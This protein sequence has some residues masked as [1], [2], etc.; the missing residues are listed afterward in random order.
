MADTLSEL[1]KMDSVWQQT[2]NWQPDDQQQLQFQRLYQLVLEGNCQLNLTRITDPLEFWEKHLWDSL[3]GVAPL[4]RD[5][6][7]RQKAEVGSVGGGEIG[8]DGA[9]PPFPNLPHPASFKVIDIGTGAGFPGIAIAITQLDWTITLLDAT[10]KKIAFL[11]TLLAALDLQNSTTL[12]DRAE[13]VGQ[14]PR[15]R[16]TYDIA[17][18]RAVGAASV[19]AEYALPLLKT[20]GLAILYRGQWTDKDTLAL[21]PIVEKLGGTIESVEKFTTPVSQSVRHCL[22]LRKAASTPIEFPRSVG[23]PTQRP[24]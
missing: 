4:F 2:L 8:S 1:P 18:A 19:C 6:S 5:K 12:V 15:Y 17:L 11:Q 21:Q 20:E 13:R 14:D 10:R 3:R 23:L 22:Y 7:R 24:L 16:E 9:I